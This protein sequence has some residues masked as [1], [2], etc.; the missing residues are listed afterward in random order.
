MKI[1]ITYIL[2]ALIVL[3]ISDLEKIYSNVFINYFKYLIILLPLYYIFLGKKYK[4]VIPYY[5]FPYIFIAIWSLIFNPVNTLSG[6]V[7]IIVL[8]T[9]ILFTSTKLIDQYNNLTLSLIGFSIVVYYLIINSNIIINQNYS[10]LYLTGR[11]DIP[12]YFLLPYIFAF[13]AIFYFL[14][15]KYVFTLIFIA[16][17]LTTGKRSTIIALVFTILM[18]IIIPKKYSNRKVNI[19]IGVTIN[20]LIV[21][22][23]ILFVSGHF[24][25][26]FANELGIKA[27]GAFTSGRYYI[28]GYLL[29]HFNSLNIFD[30]SFGIGYGEVSYYI[31]EFF[32]KGHDWNAHSEILRLAIEIGIIGTIIFISLL[33]NLK[34]RNQLI[35][36]IFFNIL[37][38]F[39]NILTYPA[40]MFLYFSLMNYYKNQNQINNTQ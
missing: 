29:D 30:L 20:L 6:I 32:K 15:K 26:L 23:I 22:F 2:F 3:I 17:G 27:M 34:N 21:A 10:L 4:I 18:S 7:Y 33:Y 31:G 13:F 8:L 24:D 38:F 11:S 12:D 19:I 35:L 39:T 9:P 1:N 25:I 14:N 5:T 40:L 28:Y 16:I 37:L 36:T